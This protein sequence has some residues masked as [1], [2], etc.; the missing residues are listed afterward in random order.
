MSSFC[1]CLRVLLFLLFYFSLVCR[2]SDFVMPNTSTQ[3]LGEQHNKN[4]KHLKRRLYN[5]NSNRIKRNKMINTLKLIL[6][7]DNESRTE[8]I[9]RRVK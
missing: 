9:K 8:I 2:F 6:D 3:K 7:Q 4:N 5:Q 1:N